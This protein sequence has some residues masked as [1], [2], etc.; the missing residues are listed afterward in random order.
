MEQKDSNK[1]KQV[2]KRIKIAYVFLQGFF[3]IAIIYL[4]LLQIADIKHYKIKAKNQ[5]YSKNF[6]MR[7]Q[8]LDRNGVRLATDQTSYNLYAHKEYFDHTP[9]ELAE[10]LSPLLNIDKKQIITSINKKATVVLLKKDVDRL[11]AEKI[12]KL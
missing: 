10:I 8:I 9:E 1:I 2:E 5:R 6:I 12:K 11:T 7:G 4:F 3:A